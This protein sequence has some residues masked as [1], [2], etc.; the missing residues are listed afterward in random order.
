VQKNLWLKKGTAGF[1]LGC[2][3]EADGVVKTIARNGNIHLV[4][5]KSGLYAVEKI[6]KSIGMTLKVSENK[7]EM[8]NF[9]ENTLKEVACY[10]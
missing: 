8:I 4:K 7:K 6:T 5:Y 9:Y 2:K 1:N 3:K 10:E